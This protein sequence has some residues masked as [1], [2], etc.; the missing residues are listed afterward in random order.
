MLGYHL[1]LAGPTCPTG[2]TLY[3]WETDGRTCYRRSTGQPADKSAA[4][5]TSCQSADNHLVRPALPQT[6]ALLAL[7][8]PDPRQP[9]LWIDGVSPGN[10]DWTP[11]GF[12]EHDYNRWPADIEDFSPGRA[13]FSETE[14]SDYE[15]WSPRR[16]PVRLAMPQDF[17]AATSDQVL[18]LSG[19]LSL[20]LISPQI[21]FGM[22]RST[23]IFHWD[24]RAATDTTPQ[25]YVVWAME[26]RNNK[27]E[28]VVTLSEMEALGKNPQNFNLTISCQDYNGTGPGSEIFKVV[29]NYWDPAGDPNGISRTSSAWD[30]DALTD[31]VLS[32]AD[33]SFIDIL[34]TGSLSVDYVGFTSPGCLALAPNGLVV[35]LQG[36]QCD[37]DLDAVCEHQ[38][39]YTQ[40][41]DECVFPFTYKDVEYKQ[42]ASVDVYQPWCAT[43][44]KTLIQVRTNLG[45]FVSGNGGIIFS[46][47]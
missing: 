23:E 47:P 5:L 45:K 42:C 7:V 19:Q 13:W 46:P 1:L 9:F 15:V 35:Q 6:P 29:M 3:P 30:V 14:N 20:G 8:K 27:T 26:T 10:N 40:E 31:S 21:V 39:C 16:L 38:S 25:Q 18:L 11:L 36:S 32:P 44:N 2:F 43:G 22:N 28:S 37:Q 4:L 33:V 34:G 12:R 24:F 41:G 17:C